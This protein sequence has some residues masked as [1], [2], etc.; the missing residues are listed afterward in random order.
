MTTRD[1]G[2]RSSKR[3]FPTKS[4]AAAV[5]VCALGLAIWIERT[6][7]SSGVEGPGVA[8]AYAPGGFEVAFPPRWHAAAPSPMSPMVVAGSSHRRP[9]GGILQRSYLSAR[10]Y[11]LGELEGGATAYE[12]ALSTQPRT[13][14]PYYS[15]GKPSRAASGA[16]LAAYRIERPGQ[17]LTQAL[18]VLRGRNSNGFAI[19]V[20]GPRSLEELLLREAR[21]MAD[22]IRQDGRVL[23]AKEIFLHAYLSISPQAAEAAR[24]LQPRVESSS[25]SGGRLRVTAAV[26]DAGT[27]ESCRAGAVPLWLGVLGRFIVERHSRRLWAH[28]M[29][30]SCPS[31]VVEVVYDLRARDFVMRQF[32]ARGTMVFEQD[33]TRVVYRP[34]WGGNSIS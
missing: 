30:V 3:G 16:Y 23:A 11:D 9:V 34:D 15:L 26:D 13:D 5:V 17:E 19:E 28:E 8:W 20:T 22:S 14:A 32:D 18:I 7:D 25:E 24:H 33:L 21:S 6:A 4:I 29:R 2:V 31:S 27:F 10:T 1:P 12:A